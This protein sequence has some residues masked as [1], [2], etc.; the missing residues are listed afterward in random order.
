MDETNYEVDSTNK[1]R[2][3]NK[4]VSPVGTRKS[5]ILTKGKS[6]TDF[7]SHTKE[8]LIEKFADIMETIAQKSIE[9]SLSHTKYLFE[10]GGVREE[11]LRQVQNNG[12]P[13]LAELLLAEVKGHRDAEQPT[14]VETVN[15]CG[16]AA[17]IS[18]G[19]SGLPV[20]NCGAKGQ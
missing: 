19:N 4:R 14:V 10:I 9:G 2:P 6:V 5:T 20:S 11:L 17:S 3:R 13:S 16:R 15:T 1:T 12:E 8:L 18:C 7:L